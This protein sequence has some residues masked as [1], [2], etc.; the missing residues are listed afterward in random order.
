VAERLSAQLSTELRALRAELPHV[1][2][3]RLIRHAR[4][5]A[6]LIT[7]CRRA[8]AEGHV[9][10]VA[11]ALTKSLGLGRAELETLRIPVD[12]LDLFPNWREGSRLGFMPPAPNAT[13]VAAGANIPLGPI[14][15]ALAPSEGAV[16]IM[17]PLL[18]G[19]VDN[20]DADGSIT[21]MVEPGKAGVKLR[22]AA[23]LVIRDRKRVRFET[24]KAATAFAR[25]HALAAHDASGNPL[26]LIPRGFRPERGKEDA[27]LDERSARRV[28]GVAVKR[29]LLYWEGGNVLFDGH[30]C[31]VGADL[32]RE[33]IGRLGIARD[34]VITILQSE[35]G[36][37]CAVL[38][39]VSRAT[40]DG[41]QDRLGR[42]GQASYHIDLDV[43]P[44]GFVGDG[45]PVVMLSDPDAGLALL[46][47]ALRHPRLSLVHGL[48][49]DVGT[50][51]QAEEY[52]RT[53]A[54]RRPRLA[55]YRGQLERLGY[56]VVEIPELRVEPSRSLAG[57][58]NLDFGFCNVLPASHGG[59]PGVY[60]LPWGIPALDRAAAA[61]W[62]RAGV[63]PIPITKFSSLAHGMMTLAAGLHCFVGP[64]PKPR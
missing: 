26:L 5:A 33:N 11:A 21:V 29:S 35:L 23:E 63:R 61:Q 2:P 42:S 60:Y 48:A 27:P 52:R 41:T 8:L 12:L 44:L 28:L 50:R 47:A 37:R 31:L 57:V 58:G 17:L 51:L 64:V 22:R 55:R 1:S 45:Q 59:R 16:P 25:D 34:E 7:W 4:A 62:R 6:L 39:E 56:R 36:V 46:P 49:P 14:R 43:T 38:G 54:E 24:G 13:L 40:F 10:T 19:L 32:I 30:R 3:H 18:R 15:L 20:L 53:A 9:V